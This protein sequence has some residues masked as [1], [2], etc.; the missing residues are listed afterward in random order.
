MGVTLAQ[1]ILAK[2]SGKSKV[3]PGEVVEANIDV[4]VF[5]DIGIYLVKY[6][7]ELGA[8]R[9]WNP[10]KI[11]VVFDHRV[12]PATKKDSEAQKEIR[13]FVREQRIKNF[14]DIGR[15]SISHQL[16][17]EGGYAIPGNVVASQD[18]YAVTGGAVG[19]FSTAHGYDLL[20]IL[21]T[22]KSWYIV[23]E[24]LKFNM[25]GAFQKGVMSR[26][27]IQW[28]VKE[29]G[30]DR[31]VYKV[32]EFHG[33]VV[34]SMGIDGR[35]SLCHYTVKLGAKAALV[36]PDEVTLSYVK[37]RA[38]EP[39]TPLKSD[40]DAE[41]EETF[42]YNVSKLEPQIATPGDPSNTKTVREIE[43]VEID[44]AFIGS[45]AAGR[46]EDL[47][48]AAK[49]LKGRTVHSRVRA[50]IV[51]ASQEIYKQ[52]LMEGL[53]EVFV[54]ANATIGFPSCGAC[55][56]SSGV[57]ASEETCITTST[58]NLPGRMG[59]S[60]AKIYLANAATVAAS[61][62]AGKIADPRNYL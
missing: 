1:K 3:T 23:P 37:P 52:A 34:D 19:S 12:P 44:Q 38:R 6:W 20:P 5:H 59:S 27:F 33:P 62:V 51:P 8:K 32:T 30:Q 53:M 9:V 36:N 41:Y 54:T 21:A 31:A 39:F 22:G 56:G 60:S 26:D 50:L 24:T 57:L 45:C 43:G 18:T 17:V 7:K 42:D 40:L 11:L 15:Q 25:S 58:T 10:D 35:M 28:L 29:I 47:T 46:M 55:S 48:V 2:A 16:I 13:E 61:S 14:Y 49:I 4:A